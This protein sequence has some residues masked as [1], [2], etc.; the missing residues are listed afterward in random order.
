[1]FYRKSYRQF[2]FFTLTLALTVVL[3]PTIASAQ[4]V[5][6]TVQ[7]TVYDTRGAVVPG[8][9]VVVRNVE[10]G[11]ERN[12]RT[13][14]EGFYVA[15]F[16]PLGRYSIKASGQGFTTSTKE[17]VEITLNQ[18]R[19]AD[20]TL[21]PSGVTEAVLVLSQE[22]PIN[23]TNGEIKGSLSAQEILEKPTANQGS[24]LTLA[25]TF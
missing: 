15:T 3:L 2:F 12:I 11:Q 25:E 19:V 21:T 7:G 23:T 18:T 17:D 22:A 10:T 6:G 20:F 8:V 16:M 9:D 1:M 14:S 5:T 4:T 24:F 13:N